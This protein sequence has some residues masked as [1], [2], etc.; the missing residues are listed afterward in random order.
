[1]QLQHII[2]QFSLKGR[3]IEALDLLETAI[4]SRNELKKYAVKES[5]FKK[6]YHDGPDY[7]KHETSPINLT[8]LVSE[9]SD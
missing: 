7:N 4:M 8:T 6:K 9:K 5:D 2:K 3:K 1:M